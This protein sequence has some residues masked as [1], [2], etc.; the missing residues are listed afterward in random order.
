MG[1]TGRWGIPFW[2]FFHA[3]S[4]KIHANH[5]QLIKNDLFHHFKSLCS[6]L[7]C[8][9]CSDHATSYLHG[10][11]VPKTIDEFKHFLYHFHN[12]VNV[13]TAKPIFKIEQL[14][15]YEKAPIYHLFVLFSHEFMKHF[16]NPKT[17]TDDISRRSIMNAFTGWCKK[18]RLFL[19]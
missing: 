3:L 7:P 15:M 2:R 12:A 8:P 9:T 5:Y 11:Q 10:R 1:N 16:Y 18:N 13:R 17:L 14:S 4:F 19:P 6:I